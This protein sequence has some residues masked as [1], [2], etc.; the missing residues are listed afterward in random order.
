[1]FK[2]FIFPLSLMVLSGTVLP[3][4]SV[5]RLAISGAI[6]P[7]TCTLNGQT[8][9][10]YFYHFDISPGIFPANGNLILRPQTQNIEVIC[11]ATTYLTFIATDERAG[12]E[13]VTGSNNYGL[14]TYNMNTKTGYFAVRVDNVTVKSHADASTVPAGIIKYGVFNDFALLG[15]NVLLTLATVTGQPAAAQI[16]AADFTITPTI[17]GALKDSTGDAALDGLVVLTF[18]FGL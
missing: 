18:A 4:P 12:T 2:I 14:G 7:P 3:A 13:L 16:F 8:E 11:D 10:T 15:K 9:E 5:A 6:T 1:M 17:N